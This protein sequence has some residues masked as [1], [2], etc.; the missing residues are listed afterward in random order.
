[1]P[2]YATGGATGASPTGTGAAPSTTGGTSPGAGGVT[3]GSGGTTGGGGTGGGTA[4]PSGGGPS[5][6]TSTSTGGQITS[7]GGST[8]G[9]GGAVPTGG[10]TSGSAGTAPTG[11][12]GNAGGSTGGVGNASGAGSGGT[13]GVGGGSTT[14]PAGPRTRVLFNDNWRFTKNDPA[15]ANSSELAYSNARQWV[16]PTG[17]HFLSN[18]G[19]WHQRPQGNLGDG[20]AYIAADYDDS[21]W[22][23]LTLPHDYAVEGP[24]TDS[25]PANMGRLPATG[26]AWY[27]KT[28][29]LP[30]EDAGRS[31]FIDLDGAMSYSMAWVNGQF[32]GG[33]PY[34]YTSYRLDVTAYVNAGE[35]NVIAVRL[36]NPVPAGTNWD[37]GSSRWYPG[38][39]IYR[40][41]W[42]V[43]TDPVHVAQWGT[44]VR[45]PQVSAA[46]AS[47]QLDV[48]VDNDSAQDV[49][50][51][52]ATD[53][54][55]VDEGGNRAGEAVASI[56]A[57]DLAITA[58]ASATAQTSGSIANPRLWGVPPTGVPNL[59]DAITTVS[60][61]GTVVDA[62][63]T[64]FGVRAFGY[65]P[66]QGLS[67]NGEHVKIKGVCNHH[68]LGALGAVANVRG[69][70]RQLE[71]LAAMG[72]N[73]VRTSHNPDTPAL[74]DLADKMGFLIL[75]EAFD[76]WFSG[77]T[78]LDHHL[79][80]A[81]W[82][83]QDLRAMI[84]RDRNHPS[85]FMWSIGNEIPEQYDGGSGPTAQGI[86]AIANDEDPTRP[87]TTGMN[88]ADPG[89]AFADA[90][91][92]IG[93]NYQGSGVRDAAPEYPDF[94]AAY[95]SKFIVG[96][97]TTDTYSSRGV[98]TFPVV[99][100]DGEPASNGGGL[101]QDG[102]VSSYD[103]Y[104]A[105]W[106]Y[107]PDLEFES[108]DRWA[109]VGGEFVWTGFDYLG[110]PD[111]HSGRGARSSYSGIIDLAG[112]PKDRFYLYQAHWR[113]DL[114]MAHILPHWTWPERDG[115][116]TP[117][118]VYTSGDEAELFVNGQSQG[119]QQK[120]QYEYRLR[121]D[122]VTY[123]AGEVSVVAYKN[124]Q[125]WATETVE[126]AGDAAALELSPDR[127]TIAGD[128]RDLCFI[129]LT[130]VD[131]E[132]RM[133][134]RA[135]NSTSFSVSG[136]GEIVATDNGDPTDRNVFSSPQRDAFSGLALAIVRAQPNQSGEITVTA[137]SQGLTQ[138]QTVITAQ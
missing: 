89:S 136:P 101:T 15:G 35:Q 57:V 51:S 91:E 77:K 37:Q 71:I 129:T 134:P 112:F 86:R 28:F 59:Y 38:A 126:T 72:S 41:V 79:F 5:G 44:Y 22:R 124:G 113:Q 56:A 84:R 103:L 20:V 96:T 76:V 6:G 81:D 1:M 87:T 46:S 21:S 26:V 60:L 75:D 54:Y 23:A 82:H 49:N 102:Q 62:Y 45:T 61:D 128:G 121:W 108:N 106:S 110:E 109:Y 85:V 7:S 11:G 27:R 32:V 93:L 92:A 127:A 122:N 50:V 94:H 138:A 115:Q 120:G 63:E 111:P 18:P 69:K 17:N 88:A 47:V 39:G 118:H 78:D 29:T 65:D 24:F 70:E 16:L 107:V 42:L 4:P 119:R 130:V 3:A 123:Q 33:W 73:A 105:D 100:P 68:D 67:V 55:E 13:A 90:M 131:S 116:V 132:G 10:F 19:D 30:A 95:P 133:V 135:S 114:P 43:T 53:L 9:S 99:G 104:H 83:E 52:V 2:N 12:S 40:D 74:Y 97:E 31:F 48:T 14:E 36:D 58:G 125:Q 34:G 64:R 98:Y 117:V 137:T 8:S 25:V 66:N 80:F